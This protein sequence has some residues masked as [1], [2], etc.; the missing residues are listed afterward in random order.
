MEDLMRTSALVIGTSFT[1]LLSALSASAAVTRYAVSKGNSSPAGGASAQFVI[2]PYTAGSQQLFSATI[3]N[4]NSSGSNTVAGLSGNNV[5]SA[6]QGGLGV[7]QGGLGFANVGLAFGGATTAT[8]SAGFSSANN[9]SGLSSAG[10]SS[11]NNSSGLSSAGFSSSNNTSGT[12]SAG[13]SSLNNNGGTTSAGFSSANNSGG[14]SSAGFSS[15]NFN[16]GLSS[17]GLNSAN[18]G[19]SIAS[20][21]TT[22][23]VPTLNSLNGLAGL[24]GNRPVLVLS[25]LVNSTNPRI[26]STGAVFQGVANTQ[27]STVTF[28]YGTLAAASGQSNSVSNIAPVLVVDDLANGSTLSTRFIPVSSG[29]VS[30]TNNGTGLTTVTFTA[31]QLGLSGPVQRIGLSLN[32]RGV[33]VV[34]NITVNGAS[35]SGILAQA[36]QS[37]P[38]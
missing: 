37:F 8:S 18:N 25:S 7:P 34:D 10:F 36:Q 1:L 26:G 15:L 12:S 11:A 29:T 17:V 20:V 2:A 30:N 31:T 28:Q 5:G 6:P 22:T 38:F 4:V 35:S 23:A 13:F 33:V 14:T 9:S 24:S 16:S 27:I 19:N 3:V 32:Q 21:N